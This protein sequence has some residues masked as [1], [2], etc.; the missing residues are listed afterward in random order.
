MKNCEIRYF[1]TLV[2]GRCR[3]PTIIVLV[4]DR[5]IRFGYSHQLGKQ[6]RLRPV[7]RLHRLLW[8]LNPRNYT[9]GTIVAGNPG[10]GLR[11]PLT[12]ELFGAAFR[13]DLVNT[14]AFIGSNLPTRRHYFRLAG[15]VGIEGKR[16]GTSPYL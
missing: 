3:Y 1:L 4:Q 12:P 8:L 11:T 6:S 14:S 10:K 13:L 2:I 15:Y 7:Q 16:Q 5:P 9:T